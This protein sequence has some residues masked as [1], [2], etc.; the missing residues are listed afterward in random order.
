MSGRNAIGIIYL[1][2][3]NNIRIRSGH[4]T[5][6]R[7]NKPDEILAVY[8]IIRNQHEEVLKELI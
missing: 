6:Y 2:S 7:I 3:I 5:G 8:T 1:V 4:Q